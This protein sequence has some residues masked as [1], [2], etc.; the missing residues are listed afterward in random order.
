MSLP[1]EVKA[2]NYLVEIYVSGV[3]I[4]IPNAYA[5]FMIV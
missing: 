5:L 4:G 2:V 1:D 3:N